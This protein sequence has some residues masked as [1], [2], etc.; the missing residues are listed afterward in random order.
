NN[1]ENEF[2][3]IDVLLADGG[4]IENIPFWGGQV[5]KDEN[6]NYILHGVFVPPQIGQVVVIGFIEDFAVNPVVVCQS[7]TPNSDNIEN[8]N[9]YTKEKCKIDKDVIYIG[10]F[11]GS[12]IKLNK[13]GSIDIIA[14][15]GKKIN[16]NVEEGQE[17]KGVARKGD[18]VI[19]N[20]SRIGKTFFE[21]L[22]NFV[23]LFRNITPLPVLPNSVDQTLVNFLIQLN[24][25]LSLN[26]VPSTILS[27]ISSASTTINAGD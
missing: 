19:A 15:K 21:W 10:H 8:L 1:K 16:L 9:A 4:Y 20:K 25:F 5:I 13:D 26:P 12:K 11:S 27:E 2:I 17:L 22:E 3:S 7:F 6:N 23:N 18:I 24:G 14:K